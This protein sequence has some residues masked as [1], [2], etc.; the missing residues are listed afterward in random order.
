M[1]TKIFTAVFAFVASAALAQEFN[2]YRIH[3]MKPTCAQPHYNPYTMQNGTVLTGLPVIEGG[4]HVSYTVV[5]ASVGMP[6]KEHAYLILVNASNTRNHAVIEY[7]IEGKG[8]TFYQTIILNPKE[9]FPIGLHMD[10]E[11][12][13]SWNLSV[14]AQ[15]SGPG[16]MEFVWHRAMDN[17]EVASKAGQEVR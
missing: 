13:G 17:A 6:G 3:D 5:Q 11:L 15:F 4:A 10:P 16:V 9:R 12:I 8:C 2:P 1:K 7:V 14:I